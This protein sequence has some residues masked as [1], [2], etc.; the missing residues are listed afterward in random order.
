MKGHGKKLKNI[1]KFV[2][3]NSKLFLYPIFRK[4]T[5]TSITRS[6]LHVRRIL[7]LRLGMDDDDFFLAAMQLYESSYYLGIT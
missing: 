2:W 3:W 1:D 5:N 4:T 6:R 7:S